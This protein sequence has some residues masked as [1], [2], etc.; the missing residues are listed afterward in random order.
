YGQNPR[1]VY[2]D[3]TLR[4]R[5]WNRQTQQPLANVP[6]EVTLGEPGSTQFV[7]LASFHTGAVGNGQPAIH[8]PDWADGSYSIHV[9]AQTPE[10]PE[11]F[12]HVV[13]LKRSA[14]L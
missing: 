3:A 9:K 6:V 14:K 7:S 8:L 10:Q 12:R 2:S 13:W 11:S 4:L 1:I 5:L